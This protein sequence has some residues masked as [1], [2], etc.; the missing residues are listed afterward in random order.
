MIYLADSLPETENTNA[1]LIKIHCLYDC[2]KTD[3]R[4]MFWVQDGDRAVISMTDGNMIIYN[5]AADTEEL[6][7]FIDLMSPVCVFGDYDT[8]CAL[9]REPAERINVMARAADIKENIEGD[10][11]S[12]KELYSLLDTD[13]LSLPEY[14]Y[15]AVDYCRRLNRDKGQMR[16]HFL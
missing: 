9:N 2:Y 15:F 11:L 14:P 7:E 4:V 16:R 1:E 5:R 12:S 6:K 8:L 13:G 10:I 3:D